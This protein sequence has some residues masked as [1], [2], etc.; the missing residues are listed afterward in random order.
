M[1]CRQLRY[2]LGIAIGV[3]QTESIDSLRDPEFNQFALGLCQM[4]F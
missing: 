2:K 4:L 3:H 1:G